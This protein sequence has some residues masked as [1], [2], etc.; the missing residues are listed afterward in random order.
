MS[1]H[2]FTYPDVGATAP[3]RLPPAGWDVLRHERLVGH[4]PERFAQVRDAILRYGMQRG[5][6]LTVAASAPVAAEG[7]E[8]ELRFRWL[9]RLGPA[10]PARVVYVLD[11]PAMAGFAYGTLPGH[12]ESGEEL[13]AVELRPDGAVRAFVYAFSRPGNRLVALG[14]PLARVLQHVF[15]RRY[16][17]AVAEA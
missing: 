13:F 5:A 12:P 4:G 9:G 11:T 1:G 10:L 7:T 8:L 16:L 15:A 3:G 6:G 2:D 14:S 17:A